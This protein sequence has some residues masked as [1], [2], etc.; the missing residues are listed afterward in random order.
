MGDGQGAGLGRHQ[1]R[2]LEEERD[3][4][5]REERHVSKHNKDKQ[6]RKTSAAINARQ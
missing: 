3:F 6:D 2:I 5:G 4:S 1:I